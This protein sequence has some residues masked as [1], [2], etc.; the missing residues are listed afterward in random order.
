MRPCLL[1]GLL[2]VCLLPACTSTVTV[3]RDDDEQECGPQPGSSG[4]CPPAWVCIDGEWQ[5]TAGACPEPTCP[6]TAPGS[7]DACLP[8]GT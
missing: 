5:D 8:V 3:D 7:G 4:W 2:L 1:P 6:T